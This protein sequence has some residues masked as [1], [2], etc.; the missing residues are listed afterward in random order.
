M[1]EVKLQL[2]LNVSRTSSASC[3][4]DHDFFT[5][6]MAMRT[7]TT[8]PDVTKIHFLPLAL[9]IGEMLFCLI[10]C[11]IKIFIGG[12]INRTNEGYFRFMLFSIAISQIQIPRF[13]I[14][15]VFLIS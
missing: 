11:L 7:L 9:E 1:D 6:G 12:L 13:C 15:I 8:E 4:A 14:C 2:V 10:I 5:T 3:T